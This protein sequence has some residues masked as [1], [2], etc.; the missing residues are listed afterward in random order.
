MSTLS[1][2]LAEASTVE[3]RSSNLEKALEKMNS[4]DRAA[5]L[6]ALEG[7]LS[8]PKLATVLRNNGYE[9]SA[10]SIKDIRAGRTVATIETLK[11]RYV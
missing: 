3:R 5:V 2:Q 1:D 4:E 10:T 9:V 7:E 8:A 6:R 11:E